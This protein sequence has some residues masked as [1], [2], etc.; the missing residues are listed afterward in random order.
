MVTFLK[1]KENTAMKKRLIPIVVLALVAVM[2]IGI[3]AIQFGQHTET[4]GSYKISGYIYTMSSTTVEA[5]TTTNVG[6]S[7]NGVTS[8]T[9][10]VVGYAPVIKTWDADSGDDFVIASAPGDRSS[11]GSHEATTTAGNVSFNTWD[12]DA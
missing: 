10:R 1:T 7:Q 11:M 12:T 9:A 8:I 5:E 2:S 3:V 6:L 4:V